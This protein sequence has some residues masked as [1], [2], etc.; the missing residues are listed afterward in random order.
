MENT[1]DNFLSHPELKPYFNDIIPTIISESDRGAVLLSVSYID[2][3]LNVL[4]DNLVPSSISNKRKKE[5]F[6]YTGPF[7]GIASKLD[8]ALVCRILSPEIIDAI[9]ELRKIRNALAHNTSTFSLKEYQKQ[10]YNIFSLLGPRVDLGINRIA[11]EAMMSNMLRKLLDMSHPIDDGKPL[12][13]GREEALEYLSNNG[14]VLSVLDEQR[15][16]WELAIGIGVISG[17]ILLYRDKILS[18]V[19][20]EKTLLNAL[21]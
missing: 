13:E 1:N 4:F 6:N 19:D 9:H 14:E 8:V 11:L 12:F 21:K 10:L 5:I 15:P 16:R 7:G 20:G 3:Q 2:E 18:A 17:M